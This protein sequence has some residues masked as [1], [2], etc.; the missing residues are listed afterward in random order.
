MSKNF[1]LLQRA[2]RDL[3]RRPVPPTVLGPGERSAPRSASLSLSS[4]EENR[5]NWLRV[6]TVLRK[7]WRLS[8]LFAGV[9]MATVAIVTL[10]IK[11]IY[12]PTARIEIDPPGEVFSLENNGSATSDIAYLETQA[13]NLRSDNLALAVIRSLNLDQNPELAGFVKPAKAAKSIIATGTVQ[14][15]P[16]ESN[17]L[18]NFQSALKIRRDTSSRLILI[19]FASH[20]P[21]LAAQVTNAVVDTFIDDTFRTQHASIMKS[22]EWLSRQLD[23]I[24]AKMESSSRDLTQFQSSIGVADLDENKSTY[25]EHM[26]ELSRQLTQ[27]QSDRIQLEAMLKNLQNGNPDSLPEVRNSPVVQQLSQKLAEQRAELSQA[28]VIYGKN[29]PAAK[30][31]QSEV[32]E[33]QSQLDAQK[34]AAVNSLRA[35]YAAAEARER[36]MTAEMR[37]TSKELDQMARYTAL[38]KE[39]QTD[40]DLYNSLYARIKEAGIAAASKSGNIQI[41]DQARVLDHPTRPNKLL[42]LGVGFLAAVF[43]GVVLAFIREEFDSRLRTLAD[44]TKWIGT[45]NIAMIPAI[46]PTN[47]HH[48]GFGARLLLGRNGDDN[49]ASAFVLDRP[50][51]PETDAVH[52]LQASLMFSQAGVTPQVLL[53]ASSFSGEGKTTVA[54]NLALALAQQGKTCL[55]DADMRKAKLS[56][57]FGLESAPGLGDFLGGIAPIESILHETGVNNLSLVPAGSSRANPGQLICSSNAQELFEALRQRCRFVIVDSVPILPFAEGRALSPLADAVVFVSR[58]GVTT[59]EAMQRSMQLL[60][61]VHAAPILEFVLN[62]VDISSAEYNQYGYGSYKS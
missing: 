6:M 29:H 47:G 27:A 20:D 54:L 26:G 40:V 39:V 48:L 34:R 42:N 4:A 51:S 1:E 12:E 30:K 21:Q 46:A 2:Y 50:N 10:L 32:D 62:G 9:V 13:Q 25:T 8:A 35:S 31:L 61:Q 14:L 43:G 52:S 19:S 57:H 60:E 18:E 44:F 16:A 58:A 17:A 24:R 49:Q 41:I 22:T 23:D 36:L 3:E 59:R 11:P 7:H 55:I 53:V 56:A 38:K 5:H 15:T 28:L 33:L 37:G 45:S